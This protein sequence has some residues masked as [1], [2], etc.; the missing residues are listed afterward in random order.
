MGDATRK[1]NEPQDFLELARIRLMDAILRRSGTEPVPLK[2]AGYHRQVTGRRVWPDIP[3]FV[4]TALL[5]RATSSAVHPAS[6]APDAPVAGAYD[7][8]QLCHD[9][10]MPALGEAHLWMGAKYDK[11]LNRPPWSATSIVDKHFPAP[12]RP[13]LKQ[14]LEVLNEAAALQEDDAQLALVAF[15]RGAVVRRRR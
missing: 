15:L 12:N 9:V 4:A 1:R 2:W 11:P 7:A 6:L 5:A 3:A 8:R 14:L 13:A 10:L